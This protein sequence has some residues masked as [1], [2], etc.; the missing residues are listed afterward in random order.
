MSTTCEPDHERRRSLWYM[1]HVDSYIG[2]HSGE[3]STMC[4]RACAMHANYQRG[5]SHCRGDCRGLSPAQKLMQINSVG[6]FAVRS[7]TFHI[8]SATSCCPSY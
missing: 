2:A 8:A 3:A 1:L 7:A 4:I 6:V 5:L